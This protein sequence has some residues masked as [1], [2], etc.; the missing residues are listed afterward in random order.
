MEK[1]HGFDQQFYD[2]LFMK[3]V[4]DGGIRMQLIASELGRCVAMQ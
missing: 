2:F 1:Y 4:E 3:I